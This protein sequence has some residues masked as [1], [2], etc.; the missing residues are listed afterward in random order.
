[1]VETQA[2]VVKIEDAFA[3]VRAERK[4]SC[5][6]CSESTCGTSV[7][8]D[9][10]GQKTPLYRASNEVGAKVGDWVV[11]GMDESALFKGTLLLYLL[12]L[13]LLFIGT[14]SG[15][16]LASS[17]DASDNYSVVGAAIGLTAGFLGLKYISAHTGLGNQFRPVILSKADVQV[18]F[19]QVE[20][21]L[22]K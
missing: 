16:L 19:M 1:M 18:H 5:S 22:K 10:F 11:V 4:S 20:G 3:Y 2:V 8:M 9:F 13:L 7:L 12:P 17:A 15:N 21:N 6:G 14:V